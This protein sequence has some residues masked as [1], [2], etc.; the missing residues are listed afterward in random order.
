[1]K[2]LLVLLIAIIVPVSA[3]D[4]EDKPEIS[5]SNILVFNELTGNF[6]PTNSTED[7]E[8]LIKVYVFNSAMRK[9]VRYENVQEAM[10]FSDETALFTAYNVEFELLGNEMVEVLTPKVFIPALPPKEVLKEPIPLVF[11]V[12][13]KEGAELKLKTYFYR[14]DSVRLG[15]TFYEMKVPKTIV[16]TTQY[17]VLDPANVTNVTSITYEYQIKISE[18]EINF[19]KVEQEI[20]LKLSVE[21]DVKLEVVEISHNRVF[22]VGKGEIYLKVKNNGGR[23]ARDAQI[24]LRLPAGFE[25]LKQAQ[26]P[27]PPLTIP[28]LQQPIL[29]QQ[30]TAQREEIV[31]YVGS[32]PS[33][34]C[35]EAKI[36]FNVRVEDPGNYT[37]YLKL[38]YLDEFG[39]IRESNEV[40]ISFLVEEMPKVSVVD[41]E[42]GVYVNSKGKVVVKIKFDK[43][44]QKVVAKLNTNA[45]LSVLSS[46]CYLGNVETGKIYN[47]LFSVRALSDA[48]AVEYPAELLIKFESSG[49][50]FELKPV[51][52]GVKVNP[53]VEFAVEG[54]AE[55]SAGEE[56]VVSFKVL[57]LA[58][59]TIKDATARLTVVDPFTSTDDSAFIGDLAPGE[60]KEIKFKVMADRD[61]T[62]K[63][64]SLNLEVKFKDRDGNWVYSDPVKVLI[65]VK[66]S[67]PP[68]TIILI[69]AAII[70]AAAVYYLKVIRKKG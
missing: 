3:L 9:E 51:I 50:V 69:A 16:N 48:E 11:R 68:Y 27:S 29:Q 4:Y 44:L 19:V 31:H 30:A 67:K 57:N 65:N 20:P 34:S 25:T 39:K 22:G 58:N 38:R 18:Y 60:W 14:I 35:A 46:E 32:I 55:V 43:D 2:K 5:V 13:I 52:F 37:L 53:K 23:D 6:V 63:I 21:R 28:F 10:F 59:M 47:A 45:P 62:P 54:L 66:P 12:K 42:S 70:A 15:S 8:K 33:N 36:K 24:V 17:R 64:Y 41:V 7:G 40:P 56:A 1:M 26:Q 49:E 61:A